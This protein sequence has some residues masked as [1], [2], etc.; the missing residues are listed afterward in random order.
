MSFSL[1]YASTT[2]S[3]PYASTTFSLPYAST[4]F[5][6]PYASTNHSAL[7]CLIIIPYIY[8]PHVGWN[9]RHK[10]YMVVVMIWLA[11]TKYPLLEWYWIFLLISRLFSYI[12]LWVTHQVYYKKQ[13]LH[14][15][16][17]C[18]HLASLTVFLVGSV[19]LIFLVFCA[20]FFV[21]VGQTKDDIYYLLLFRWAR[22]IK[23]KE[24]RLV[25]CESE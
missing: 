4:T 2:F 11:V 16:H 18:K 21:L 13:E 12:G 19:L 10:N 23:E 5:S 8:I 24:Q 14:V 22:S 9:H 20:W 7:I 15:I 3:L 6:L 17:I 25:G 1:P